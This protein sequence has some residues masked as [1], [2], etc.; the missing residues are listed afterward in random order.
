MDEQ[1]KKVPE[2]TEQVPE[3]KKN[4]DNGQVQSQEPNMQQVPVQQP[5]VQ[6]THGQDPYG[7]P[8]YGPQG[9]YQQPYPP[10]PQPVSQPGNGL[11]IAS[12]VLGICSIP[13]A[14]FFSIGGIVCGI[15]GLILA[16]MA[17]NRGN[18]S[19]MRTGGLICSIIGLVVSIA[20]FI[21][22]IV[23]LVMAF[24]VAGSVLGTLGNGGLNDII[25]NLGGNRGNINSNDLNSLING[26]I[27]NYGGNRGSIDSNDLNNLINGLINNIS[28]GISNLR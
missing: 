17:K 18:L 24:S 5:F 3:D 9:M 25:N 20:F 16:S 8:Q 4:E 10:Y 21:F 22:T 1:E 6:Q 28:D 2:T 11:A 12:L 23:A 7:Q 14:F 15:I 27:D 19:G 26:L 13:L